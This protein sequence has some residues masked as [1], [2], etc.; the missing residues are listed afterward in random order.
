[1]NPKM[2]ASLIAVIA[3]VAGAGTYGVVVDRPAMFSELQA[4][5]DQ[6]TENLLALLVIQRSDIQNR[7][8]FLEDRIGESGMTDE[9]KQR[10]WELR[11][12]YT[13]LERAISA[14][15]T[16]EDEI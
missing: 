11:N 2:I 6:S 5:A 15:L 13:R 12:E 16:K 1:M 10:L 14:L 8:W 4:V 3:S 9:R 7:I